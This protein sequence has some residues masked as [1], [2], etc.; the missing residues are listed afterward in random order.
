MLSL[1]FLKKDMISIQ[2]EEMSEEELNEKKKILINKLNEKYEV[3][4]K[5]DDIEIVHNPKVSIILVSFFYVT[6]FVWFKFFFIF[7]I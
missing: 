7:H 2:I 6:L 5:D 4:I 3:E 1:L